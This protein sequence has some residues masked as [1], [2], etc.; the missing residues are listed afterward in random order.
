M[1]SSAIVDEPQHHHRPEQA[2][3]AMRA[4]LLHHEQRDQDHHRQ[5]HDVRLEQRRGDVQPFDG[6]EHRNGRRDHAVAVE[7][8]R[9]EDA[10]QDQH[11]PR[12]RR[13]RRCCRRRGGISAVSA[14]MPPSPWLSARMTMAMYLIEMT[15]RAR[16]RPARERRGRSREVGGTGCVPK[17]HSRI[18]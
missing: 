13:A 15:I 10:E 16:R 14:R 2:A 7:Q 9:A 1:P 18:V 12:R 4:E 6:A 11:R 5:R 8:R 3:D 17:K